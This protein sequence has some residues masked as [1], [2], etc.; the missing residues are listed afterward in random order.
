VPNNGAT[1]VS[2][3]SQSVGN[4]ILTVVLNAESSFD[5][6]MASNGTCASRFASERS[7]VQASQGAVH[8]EV[9]K[10]LLETKRAADH[11]DAMSLDN[12]QLIDAYSFSRRAWSRARV[13][14]RG[15]P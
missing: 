8:R 14:L 3:A 5:D 9:A 2:T 11:R 15:I 6:G 13:S 10:Q 12:E 7:H 1:V 4:L